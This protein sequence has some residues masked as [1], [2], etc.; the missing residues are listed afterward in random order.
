MH[1]RTQIIWKCCGKF[2]A[3]CMK[4]MEDHEDDDD[5]FFSPFFVRDR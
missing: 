3:F 4:G 1:G 5:D 2:E